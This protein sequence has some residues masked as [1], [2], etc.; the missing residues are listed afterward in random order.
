MPQSSSSQRMERLIRKYIQACNNADAEAIAACFCT[1]AVHYGPS[2]PKWSG[3]VTIGGELATRVQ[4]QG[5]CWTVDQLCGDVDRCAVALEWTR[6]NR[7]HTRIVR[8]VDWFVLEPHTF[9]IQEVGTYLSSDREQG[10]T[11]QADDRD[12]R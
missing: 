5:Y 3:A 6:F 11:E 2:G 4:E 10:A 9:R 12:A 1:E 8:G 7:E